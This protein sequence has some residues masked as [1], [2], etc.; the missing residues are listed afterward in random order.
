MSSFIRDGYFVSQALIEAE[1]PRYLYPL[2]QIDEQDDTQIDALVKSCFF[3]MQG[4]GL[5]GTQWAAHLSPPSVP[6]LVVTLLSDYGI[7]ELGTTILFLGMKTDTQFMNIF[8]SGRAKA[9][10]LTDL[11][12]LG[13]G[14]HDVVYH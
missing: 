9:Q 7:N 10:L 5:P 8:T 6:P 13:P 3:G 11:A 1:I 12:S 4:A 2:K 14:Q